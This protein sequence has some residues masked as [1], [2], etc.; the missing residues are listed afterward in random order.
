MFVT[1]TI[2][3]MF[4]DRVRE[5]RHRVDELVSSSGILEHAKAQRDG[6]KG[7]G[8]TVRYRITEEQRW[9]LLRVAYFPPEVDVVAGPMTCSPT[10]EGL[11]VRFGPVRVGPP[12]A[13][14]HEG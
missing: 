9:H 2:T 12:D 7:D 13:Q 10:R 5:L 3:A 1:V 14:L 4:N 11:S 8:V 6:R